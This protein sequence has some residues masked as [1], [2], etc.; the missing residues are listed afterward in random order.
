[1]SI[2]MTDDVPFSMLV[3]SAFQFGMFHRVVK[4]LQQEFEC[5]TD[6]RIVA[7]SVWKHRARHNCNCVPAA[8]DVEL[9]SCED[10]RP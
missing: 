6:A 7:D 8:N 9:S 3:L 1:M 2:A 10:V 5:G 4:V